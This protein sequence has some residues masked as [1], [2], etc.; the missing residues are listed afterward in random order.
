MP[1]SDYYTVHAKCICNQELAARNRV[2]C[3]WPQPDPIAIDRLKKIAGGIAEWL[4]RHEPLMPEEWIDKYTGYKRARYERAIREWE[5]SGVSR[6][7]SYVTAFVKAEKLIDPRKDP[8]MIQARN[9]V[10]NV[11]LGNYLKAI[12][13]KLYNVGGSRQ[14]ARYFPKGRLIAKGLNMA[15]RGALLYK[16]W[17]ELKD[18]VALELDCSRFDAHCS[19]KLLRIEH[20]VYLKC[21]QNNKELSR[22]LDWQIRNKCFTE[23][24]IKYECLG[25]RMSGDMNTALGNC[26]IMLILLADAF[27]QCG[28]K[29][30]QFR[31]LDDGDDCVVIVER[32]V[33]DKVRELFPKLFTSYG[34]TLKIESVTSDFSKVTLCGARCIRVG[35]IRK[36]V[37]NPKRTIGKARILLGSKNLQ[38]VEK[39]VGT[40]GQCLLAL[41]A[42]VPVLQAH[43]MALRRATRRILRGTPGSFVYRLAKDQNWADQLPEPISYEAR[44]DFRDAFDISI[45]EQIEIE[46]WFNDVDVFEGSELVEEGS[47]LVRLLDCFV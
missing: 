22:L 11:A 4:G 35:G 34:H 38:N 17:S 1:C 20:R 5:S 13:H 41:H 6:K 18:P 32:E 33:Q 12:E 25:R 21:F 15:Q 26:V 19:D 28:I 46:D 14:L 29:P 16:R 44:C 7:H 3:E 27:R 31:I 9:P 23:G 2:L 36:C 43:A 47:D 40:I 24:G 42:G 39:Y 37:L 8:R 45:E 30:K 10:Y